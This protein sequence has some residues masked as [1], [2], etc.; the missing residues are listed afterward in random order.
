MKR[1]NEEDRQ[2]DLVGN[3]GS[4]ERNMVDNETRVVAVGVLE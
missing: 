3:K 1:S 4:V 2:W